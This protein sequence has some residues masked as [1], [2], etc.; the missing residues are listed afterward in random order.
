MPASV[1]PAE[2]SHQAAEGPTGLYVLLGLVALATA[3]IA[4]TA[5]PLLTLVP[6]V[7]VTTVYLMV[8][9]PLRWSA[10]GL[11][12][13]ALVPDETSEAL[14]G[15]WRTPFAV[16]G[17]LVQFNVDFVTGLPGV[18]LT[19]LELLAL[20]V[21]GIWLHRR[22]T[23]SAIDAPAPGGRSS[24]VA[25]SLV[26]CVALV[27]ASAAFGVARGLPLAPWKLRNLLHPVMLAVL[28][29]LVLRGPRD[30]LAMGRIVVAGAFVRAVLAIVVQQLGV[31]QTGGRFFYATSH[32]DSPLFAVGI[33]LPLV[34]L[35]ERPSRA[36]LLRAALIVPVILIGAYE[37]QRR[38]FW[39]SAGL[40]LLVLYLLSP[41][42]GWK[43]AAQR[44]LAVA[45]P[46]TALYVGVGWSA[47]SGFFAPVKTLRSVVDT[48]ADHS[49]Y[50]R[51]V[52]NWNIAM[53]MRERPLLGQGLG[54]HYTEF[55]FNDDISSI[56]K[57]YREWPH[58]TVLGQLLLLGLFGF[59]AVWAL[60]AA[61]LF[62]AFRS[63][64]LA[65]GP[66]GRVA[67]LGCAGALVACHM[68]GYGDTGAH[69]TQY[70]VVAALALAVASKL[71]VASGAWPR[72]A[73]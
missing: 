45:L 43:R 47:S 3:A 42:Q 7:L 51:E 70:K 26:L 31:A 46:V 29:L 30:Y 13:L 58:N 64:R 53:S 41:M 27:L 67:A 22:L 14:S 72:R 2:T 8:R 63:L 18:A 21:F 35:L 9:L 71:A 56:Y 52:E 65:A 10:F 4:A 38:I 40:M 36:R 15:Q 37:N 16:L 20:L 69:Y 33:F 60:W 61:G 17:D 1:Q 39:V 44:L 32:G 62:L 57:E 24:A 55:M 54:G 19:G 66:E 59:T 34:D 50:W 68:L 25:W 5:R 28:F 6:V 48:S 49:A 23:G 12:F 11:A 73:R